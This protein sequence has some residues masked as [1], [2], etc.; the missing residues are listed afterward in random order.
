M[1]NA[2]SEIRGELFHFADGVALAAVEEHGVVL[3]HHAVSVVVTSLGIGAGGQVF[4]DLAEDPGV[5]A[6]GTADHDGVAARLGDYADGI[7]GGDDVAVADDGNLYSSF[8]LGDA[9]PV[10]FSAVTL[11]A[12]AG[13][14]GNRLETAVL[15]E[16]P[17]ADGDQLLVIPA[18]TELHSERNGDGGANF[19]EDALDEREVAEE[20]GASI[21]FTKKAKAATG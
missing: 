13:V 20:T 12:G 2:M 6:G 1:A 16:A 7:L 5:G 18:G 4:L 3:A 14:E 21:W 19:T 11:L 10:G 17:H 8:D 9:G 15:G